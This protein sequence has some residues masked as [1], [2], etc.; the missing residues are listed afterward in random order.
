M[1]I[2]D[3]RVLASSGAML[4]DGEFQFKGTEA[5]GSV[6]PVGAMI[7]VRSSPGWFA[8]EFALVGHAR[9]EADG[10]WSADPPVHS[11]AFQT[12]VPPLDQLLDYPSF[13]LSSAGVPSDRVRFELS[14]EHSH[15]AWV[16]VDRFSSE[17]SSEKGLRPTLIGGARTV[18]IEVSR[19][20]EAF[21]FAIEARVDE[22]KR[23]ETRAAPFTVR[24]TA[25]LTFATIAL[26]GSRLWW[27]GG[28]QRWSSPDEGQSGP[29]AHILTLDN[30]GGTPY[31]RGSLDLGAG[32]RDYA[33]GPWVRAQVSEHSLRLT[34]QR[35]LR[36]SM[37]FVAGNN[38]G[39][40]LIFDN[41]GT[42]AWKEMLADADEA[43]L[44]QAGA[45]IGHVQG[46][47]GRDAGEVGPHIQPISA[48]HIRLRR[49]DDGLR[50]SFDGLLDDVRQKPSQPLLGPEFHGDFLI[51]TAFLFAR[52]I[53]LRDQWRER[54]RRL[55][56]S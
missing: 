30:A 28:A 44:E 52:G 17:V 23:G 10:L 6:R 27:H 46:V 12:T 21:D 18:V 9:C 34:P 55:G 33:R 8:T 22:P 37:G 45:G 54:Q 19:T 2:D 3:G 38:Y 43:V 35:E 51:P 29:L 50:I 32:Q 5:P 53:R 4:A 41:L 24:V 1:N 26:A 14:A 25:N 13:A 40:D 36:R 16:T 31:F 11:L 39:P 47:T 49:T 20:A 56:T 42:A 48:V 15:F 7:A